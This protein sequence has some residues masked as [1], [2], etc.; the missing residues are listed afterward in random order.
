MP[1]S[2][3]LDHRFHFQELFLENTEYKTEPG[4]HYCDIVNDTIATQNELKT[5]GWFYVYGK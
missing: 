5:L 1:I 4:V 2:R 3:M